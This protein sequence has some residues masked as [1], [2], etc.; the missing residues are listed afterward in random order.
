VL[1]G[2]ALAVLALDTMTEK[3]ENLFPLEENLMKKVEVSSN[4]DHLEEEVV[5][6]AVTSMR[7]LAKEC[8]LEEV[9]VVVAQR[10]M[11]TEVLEEEVLAPA[12]L[13]I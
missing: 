10:E 11:K 13:P 1:S 2:V 12:P 7:D 4:K 6:E 9:A 8:T 5:S 3:I